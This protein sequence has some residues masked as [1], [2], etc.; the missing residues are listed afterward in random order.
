MWKSY[1]RHAPGLMKG[2]WEVETC[3]ENM[4]DV[5]RLVINLQEMMIGQTHLNKHC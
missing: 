2:S 3:I 4:E 1:V 5:D